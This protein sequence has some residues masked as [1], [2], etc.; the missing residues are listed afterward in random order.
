MLA[1]R[2]SPYQIEKTSSNDDTYLASLRTHAVETRILLSNPMKPERERMVVRAFLRCLGIS[3]T[4]DEIVSGNDEP[5][6]VLLVMPD[7]RNGRFSSAQL[8]TEVALQ[9][10]RKPFQSFRYPRQAISCL[11]ARAYI[12]M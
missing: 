6:D 10:L 11:Q 12:E 3:F 1:N 5:V 8:C 7:S 4:E 9:F 2:W